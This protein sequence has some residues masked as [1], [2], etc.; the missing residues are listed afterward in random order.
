MRYANNTRSGLTFGANRSNWVINP[1]LKL[2]IG[3]ISLPGIVPLQLYV[4]PLP[5]PSFDSKNVNYRISS[6]C[7][8]LNCHQEVAFFNHCCKT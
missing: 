1:N 5:P 4:P 8:T 2:L 6:E 7:Y 3:V